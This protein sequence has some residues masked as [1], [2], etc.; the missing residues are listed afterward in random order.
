MLGRAIGS[1]TVAQ[2]GPNAP[3]FCLSPGR[4]GSTSLARALSQSPLCDC[5]HEPHP[6]LIAEATRWRYRRRGG[7]EIVALLR[8]SRT[9]ADGARIYGE[10]SHKMALIV[11]LIRRAFPGARFVWVTRDGR[12][13][14]RSA[15]RL[16]WHGDGPPDSEWAAWRPRGDLA[17]EV[18]SEAWGAMD[19]F[20]RI[21]WHWSFVNR[22]IESDLARAPAA[23]IRV[24]L[25]ELEAELPRI[26]EH[27]GVVP[28]AFELGRQNER[29]PAYAAGRPLA[30]LPRW[31]RWDRPLRG[32]FERQC[33]ELM[34]RLYPGWREVGGAAAKGR[35]GSRRRTAVPR[36][37]AG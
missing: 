30:E 19:R 3:F 33:G 12:D 11:P 29:W 26:C 6:Q 32:A 28:V 34:D 9:P 8:R 16:G 2:A 4:S 22:V 27:V 7:E 37:P 20:E 13:F 10:T 31:P 15:F 24:R 35:A 18:P 23:A 5:R 17:G 36:H 1:R 14:V 25:E 21:C